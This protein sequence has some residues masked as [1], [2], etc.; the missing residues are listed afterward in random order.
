MAASDYLFE[1]LPVLVLIL[2]SP[3]AAPGDPD[4][5]EVRLLQQPEHLLEIAVIDVSQHLLLFG[6]E[7]TTPPGPL[8]FPD[9][10]LS[11]IQPDEAKIPLLGP[12]WHILRRGAIQFRLRF[13]RLGV[14]ER[15]ERGNQ[16][17]Q[18]NPSYDSHTLQHSLHT[19]R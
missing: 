16:S 18:S 14:S 2:K 15:Y 13:K 8:R 7:L 4:P 19:K 6:A 10:D 12:G 11:A 5:V 1:V 17:N 9:L 3:A